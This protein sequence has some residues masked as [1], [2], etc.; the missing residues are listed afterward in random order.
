MCQHLCITAEVK[1]MLVRSS[2]RYCKS[3]ARSISV[4]A[5]HAQGYVPC[6]LSL[7]K[8]VS[9][10]SVYDQSDS[11]KLVA[12]SLGTQIQTLVCCGQVTVGCGDIK[13]EQ[14]PPNKGCPNKDP[15]SPPDPPTCPVRL[16]NKHNG[17]NLSPLSCCCPTHF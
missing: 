9:V 14:R 12:P 5:C 8:T 10:S 16:S 4:D 7:K 17:A 11:S 6:T 13:P 1:E 2:S 15:L 3:L